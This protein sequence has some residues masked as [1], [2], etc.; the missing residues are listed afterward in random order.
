[1]KSNFFDFRNKTIVVVGSSGLIGKEI[2]KAFKKFNA[3]IVK[4]DLKG[5]KE[6]LIIKS[7]KAKKQIDELEKHLKKIKKFHIFVNCSYPKNISWKK[8]TFN[9]KN[10]DSFSENISLHLNNYCYISKIVAEKMKKDKVKGSIINFS[11]IY[12]IVAQD[13]N[14]YSGTKMTEN[15]AYGSIKAG[16]INFTK[17]LSSYYSKFDIRANCISPGGVFE[18]SM[19][20]QFISNYKK[21]VPIKRLAKSWEIAYPVLFLASNA[22]S[23]MSGTNLVVDGGWTSI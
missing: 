20:K 23:Y 11:S 13:L 6:T 19:S 4:I 14:I 2:V 12:G 16:I 7:K 21:R 3:K 1:M 18:P 10:Y 17:L 8:M 9:R 15:I 22:S 5:D